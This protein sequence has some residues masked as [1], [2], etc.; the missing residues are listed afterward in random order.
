VCDAGTLS[1]PDQSMTASQVMADAHS[2]SATI[3]RQLQ[4]Q[5]HRRASAPYC[6]RQSPQSVASSRVCRHL[7]ARPTARGLP[8]LWEFN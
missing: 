4:P 5:P 3:T 8:K 1:T 7:T 2:T 6:R